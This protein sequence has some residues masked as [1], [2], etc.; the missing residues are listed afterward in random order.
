MALTI[1]QLSSAT[2][3]CCR[4]SQVAFATTKCVWSWGSSARLASWRNTAAHTL[5]VARV[6]CDQ[7]AAPARTRQAAKLFQFREGTSRGAIV[8]PGQ[9]F[10]ARQRVQ[11]RHALLRGALE[12]EEADAALDVALRELFAGGRVDVLA[13]HPKGGISRLDC[14]PFRQAQARGELAL[15]L[16]GHALTCRVVVVGAKMLVQVGRAVP[17]FGHREHGSIMGENA[18]IYQPDEQPSAD[19]NPVS[20]LSSQA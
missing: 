10:I 7:A 5:P 8:R 16:T 12:I 18:P 1:S 17:D 3:L 4:S 13:Q 9:A 6:S 15:P 14:L 20:K 11:N 2:I 19:K